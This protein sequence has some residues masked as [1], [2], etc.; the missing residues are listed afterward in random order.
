[1]INPQAANESQEHRT[2]RFKII[3]NARSKEVTGDE[4]SFEQIVALAFNPV[5]TGPNIVFTVTFR[6]GPRENPE[7]T[8]TP[9]E[10]VEIKEGMV[11]DVTATDKS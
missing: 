9:G 4:Q 10:T 7:G 3:V 2:K 8:L 1:M 5:P 6:K 11:F